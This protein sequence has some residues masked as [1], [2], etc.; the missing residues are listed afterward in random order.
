MRRVTSKDLLDMRWVSDPQLSPDGSKVLFTV[1][2][3]AKEDGE[4]KYRT[5]IYL[6]EDGKVRQLTSGPRGD[7]S[8]RWSPCGRHI[9]FL[10]DRGKEKTQIQLIS[11]DGG[12]ARQITFRKSGVG[13][14]VWSPCGKKIAFA[15]R[16]E[17]HDDAGNAGKPTGARVVTRI[18]YKMN[19]RGLLS[20]GRSQLF[21]VDIESGQ[22]TQVTSGEYSCREPEWSPCGRF[23]AFTSSR[24]ED[25]ETKSI[26]DIYIV[27]VSGG[28]MRK[29]TSSDAVLGG[30]SWSPDGE[31]IACYGHD[32]SMHGATVPG[33]CVVPV[34][35]DPVK[36]LTRERQLHV[37][38]SASG[39][40]GGSP[41]HKPAWTKDSQS[42]YFSAMQRGRTD[43]YKVCVS[44]GE[45]STVT[46][47]N[48]TVAGWSKADELDS[49]AVHLSS[50]ATIGDIFVVED[51]VQSEKLPWKGFSCSHPGQFDLKGHG[52]K[53]RRL[54]EVNNPLLSSVHISFPE[55][56]EV[57]SDPGA[58]VNAWIMKPVGWKEGLKYPCVLEIHG[59]P[60]SAYGPTFFHEFQFLASRGY[61][62]V[63]ANP[64]G[65]TSYGQQFEAAIRH[66]WGGADYRDLMAVMDYVQKLSWVDESRLGVLGGSYGGYMTNWM[67]TQTDLFRAAVTMRSTCNRMSQF[68]TSDAAYRNGQF[69]FDGDPWDNPAA[70]LDRSPIMY[71]RNVVTPVM[72]IHSEEDLRCPIGQAEEFFVALKKT[73]KTAVMVRF[74]GENHE[75]SRSGKPSNRIE[76]LEYIAAWFDRYLAPC[77]EDYEV[78]LEREEALQL[79]LP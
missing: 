65:S 76:R 9:A 25:Y 61:G 14:P 77:P 17:A 72:I 21:V 39:D 44:S 12:E 23:L 66:D 8:P 63:F 59:G 18:Q 48:C 71:V 40:M 41:G 45:I 30:P 70:Y 38:G 50:P 3:I 73:G 42:I 28:D 19:G 16:E 78:P 6:A 56:F 5:W 68:G 64:R 31:F 60:H 11:L 26:R 62:V 52:G 24:F 47:G 20:D 34:S 4:E 55:E 75:L 32:N 27:P 74:P 53:I 7:F 22:V 51:T 79:K 54:T 37:G 43:L 33:V 69:E 13:V 10:S 49:F 57:E 67:V 46:S 35:G 1:R 2:S 15:A 36:F 29:I 58:K